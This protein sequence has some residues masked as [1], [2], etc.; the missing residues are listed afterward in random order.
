MRRAIVALLVLGAC[1]SHK[2]SSP[3]SPALVSEGV[4][5]TPMNEFGGG[6]GPGGE[7]YFSIS[8]Q[9]SY[10]YAIA[11]SHSE[12]GR[13]SAPE[14][15]PFSTVAKNFD[16]VLSPDGLRLYFIS[17]RSAEG[18]LAQTPNQDVWRAE[19]SRVGA[20]W[21]APQR[22][23]LS[24]PTFH[25]VFASEA[26]DGTLYLAATREQRGDIFVAHRNGDEYGPLE[27]IGAPID[28]D[29]V[30]GE[31]M[32]APDQ[33]F[34]LFAAYERAGGQGDW[35]IYI[36]K[37]DGAGWSAP[38]N[39]GPLVN[40]PARDYSPRLGP[41]GHTLYFSSERNFRTG[42]AGEPLTTEA[43]DAGLAG[44]RNGNGNLYSIDLRALG[45][46]P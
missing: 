11:V 23:A 5:S 45:V 21:S 20:P 34:L 18:G 15:A 36:S 24:S 4:I 27:P 44:V 29:G 40:T 31:P 9:R 26:A 35:D 8:A 38:V 13:W 43:L 33:S 25:E 41:D 22:L 2:A 6:A 12:R 28:T 39:L 3:V 30:E 16:P 19:R 46:L 32:I 7:F 10:M 42:H 37:R 17:D 1:A 14:I